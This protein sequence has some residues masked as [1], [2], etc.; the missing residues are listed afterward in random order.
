M[1]F[2]PAC[3]FLLD[4][5]HDNLFDPT[6][7]DHILRC[8]GCTEEINRWDAQNHFDK[9]IA[10]R[11]MIR[12]AARLAGNIARLKDVNVGAPKVIVC[13]TCNENFE[14]ERKRGRPPVNC[15]KCRGMEKSK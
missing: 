5:E 4:W 3:E 14:I 7:N 15:S 10:E 9:H 12:E 13:R 1:K 8:K 2:D 6:P 11:K